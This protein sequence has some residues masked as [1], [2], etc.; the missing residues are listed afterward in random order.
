MIGET[1]E[2]FKSIVSTGRKEANR[3]NTANSDGDAGSKLSD[4]WTSI[5]DGRILS[6][7]EALQNKLIDGLGELDDAFAK[8][9]QLAN[10]PDAKVVKY[11][12]PFS[13]SRFLRVFGE[14]DSKIELQLPKQLV[15]QLESGRAYFL[16]SY[17][18]P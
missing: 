18:A 10:A 6:G 9:K 2:K 3:Q 7:K 5:A 14:S 16:P 12:P 1:F 11:A 8:A 17:Y 4:N 13:L 15:P